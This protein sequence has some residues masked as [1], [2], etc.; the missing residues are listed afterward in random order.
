MCAW[1]VC[2]IHGF[3]L[4]SDFFKILGISFHGSPFIG[5]EVWHSLFAFCTIKTRTDTGFLCSRCYHTVS[6][7]STEGLAYLH[8]SM[9]L[10]YLMDKPWRINV[11]WHPAILPCFLPLAILGGKGEHVCL[12]NREQP[13]FTFFRADWSLS[14]PL[15]QSL[16]VFLQL[17]TSA[18]WRILLTFL[19]THKHT[20]P[21]YPVSVWCCW[22]GF[23]SVS[24]NNL[25]GFL[26]TVLLMSHFSWAPV[27]VVCQHT[28]TMYTG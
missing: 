3:G 10:Y 15:L 2:L 16:S 19:Y 5:R 23:Y 13:V 26:P 17:M 24:D 9:V 12:W 27:T 18:L 25:P 8:V 21:L 11:V 4:T 28:H 6:K 1:S 14:W 20:E 22:A 7:C